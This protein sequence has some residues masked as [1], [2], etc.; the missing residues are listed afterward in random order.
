VFE[1]KGKKGGLKRSLTDMIGDVTDLQA[2]PGDEFSR[3]HG[4]RLVPIEFLQPNPGQPRRSFA[5]DDLRELALSIGRKGILQ[6]L[7][8]RAIG[9]N[10][11]QIVAGER[12]WRAAQQAGLHE[13]PVMVKDLR[14]SE[15]LE[16]AIIENIQRSDLNAVEEAEGYRQL[17]EQFDYTQQDLADAVGKTRSYIANSTRL[18]SLPEDVLTYLRSGQ[19]AAGHARAL[20]TAQNPSA[21]AE[22]VIARS[23]SVRETERLVKSTEHVDVKPEDDGKKTS[24]DADI[25]TLERELRAHLGLSVHITH[26]GG[27]EKGSI[28]ISYEK[29]KDF[30]RVYRALIDL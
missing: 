29:L 2:H 12:R 11:Y 28:K 1:N 7:I 18:L 22:I 17:A 19:L 27:Q 8:V 20:V 30:D 26:V 21:L 23:L 16:V 4:V 3:T 24:R 6:P 13:V 25:V 9:D 15:V 5:A 10:R 14:E